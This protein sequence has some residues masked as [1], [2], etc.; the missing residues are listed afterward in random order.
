MLLMLKDKAARTTLAPAPAACAADAA[1]RHIVQFHWDQAAL[2][3]IDFAAVLNTSL[4]S[5]AAAAC[6]HI[7]WRHQTKPLLLPRSSGPS[8]CC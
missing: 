3:A 2:A 4:Q 5:A 6:R 8:C 1:C 7:V